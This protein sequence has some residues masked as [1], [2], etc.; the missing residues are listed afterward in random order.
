METFAAL[1]SG[2]FTCCCDSGAAVAGI[3]RILEIFESRLL[4]CLNTQERI[5]LGSKLFHNG[6]AAPQQE[7]GGRPR[8]DRRRDL[9][10]R[11]QLSQISQ[12]QPP[13]G[14]RPSNGR[15]VWLALERVLSVCQTCQT[16]AGGAIKSTRSRSCRIAVSMD[17]ATPRIL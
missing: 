10:Q 13:F 7:I 16:W 3:I 11:W 8:A 4:S 15:R 6:F 12:T 14:L 1:D 17:G 9:D 2:Y 5:I